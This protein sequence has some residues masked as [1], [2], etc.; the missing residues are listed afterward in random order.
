MRDGVLL[1]RGV[2]LSSALNDMELLKLSDTVKH[3]IQMHIL[4]SIDQLD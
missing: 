4:N 1:V 2:V 3:R